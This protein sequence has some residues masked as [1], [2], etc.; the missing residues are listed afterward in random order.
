MRSD[1]SSQE[2][3]WEV[4]HS[5]HATAYAGSAG[6][7]SP[8][9]RLCLSAEPV[10]LVCILGW[11]T[12][13]DA[14]WKEEVVG[15]GPRHAHTHTRALASP[16]L[17]SARALSALQI[18]TQ[19]RRYMEE[20]SSRGCDVRARCAHSLSHVDVAP[21][22]PREGWSASFAFHDRHR[23]FTRDTCLS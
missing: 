23:R 16:E 11:L 18:R 12:L 8:P 1:A 15:P 2:V 21:R 10:G 7:S 13:S 3:T 9:E 19:A 17:P 6:P 14:T 20:Y 5:E 22:S 4:T